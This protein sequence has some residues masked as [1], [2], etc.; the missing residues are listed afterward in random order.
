MC[1]LSRMKTFQPCTPTPLQGEA[2][3]SESIGLGSFFL[4]VPA[5][6]TFLLTAL[7]RVTIFVTY[8]RPLVLDAEGI[9]RAAPRREG[10]PQRV[11][12]Y[13]EAGAL[14]NPER[15]KRGLWERQFPKPEQSR[16][17]YR[18]EQVP[19]GRQDGIPPR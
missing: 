19:V 18:R 10:A 8:A 4:S 17:Q 6:V 7:V 5:L 11:V 9:C 3:H 12:R 1:G 13:R 16:F 15:R 14:R 2:R